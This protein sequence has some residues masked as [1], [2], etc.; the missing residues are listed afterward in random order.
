[1]DDARLQAL[2]GP[3]LDLHREILRA[4]RHDRERLS[5]RVTA[6]EFLQIV[7]GSLRYAWLLPLSELIVAIDEALDAD[8]DDEAADPEA[9]VARLRA[10]VAPPDPDTAFGQQY[11]RLLQVAPGVVVSHAA[12]LPLL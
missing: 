4:E 2:R 6:A 7:T 1:M 10:L 5:G 3:L 12:L 8:A 9:L 11:L